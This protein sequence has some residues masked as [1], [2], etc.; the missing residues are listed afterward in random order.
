MIKGLKINKSRTEVTGMTKR[1]EIPAMNKNIEGFAI[2]QVQ[3]FK[4]LATLMRE[5][6]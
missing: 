6:G 5:D 3:K 2:K 1:R 4:Y